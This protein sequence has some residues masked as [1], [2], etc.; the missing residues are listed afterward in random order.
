MKTLLLATHNSHKVK[1]LREMLSQS[2]GLSDAFTVLSFDDI[3][4]HEE[5]IEDGNSFEE[6]AL[7]KACVG[8]ALGYITVADDSGL[9]V[10]ALCGAPGVYSARYAGENATDESNRAKLL[11]ALK[12][13]PSA[14][15]SAKFVSVICCV[16]PDGRQFSVRGECE[17]MILN[18]P[19]GEGG[20]GYDP[21][22][23]HSGI[24]KSFGDATEEEKNAISHRGNAM[25]AFCQTLPKYL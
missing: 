24:G 14:Q 1:E 8:A 15:R 11:E 20:F 21:L 18:S 12:N 7:I 2:K 9:A 22:F 16:F 19:S 3:D 17:G 4:Y 13:V 10:D 25:Q 5:I 6:N 23:Y